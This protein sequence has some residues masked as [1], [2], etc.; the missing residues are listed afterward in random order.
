MWQIIN[1][2]FCAMIMISCLFAFGKIVVKKE[3][4]LSRYKV[5]L[6]FL[7]MCT[8]Y[9]LIGLFFSRTLKTLLMFLTNA[10]F[11]KLIFSIS[12]KKSVFVTFIYT[13]LMIASEVIELYLLTISCVIVFS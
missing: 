13:L 1:I 8:L 11:Y 6:L 9:T 2:Y 4:N 10:I 5:I 7:V 3:I 12:N